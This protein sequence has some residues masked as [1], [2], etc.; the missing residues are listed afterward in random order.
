MKILKSWLAEFI[1]NPDINDL[2]RGGIEI[3]SESGDLV[4]LEI[5]ANRPDLLSHFGIARE[6]SV[7]SGR[8]LKHSAPV[9]IPSAP[10]PFPITVESEHCARYCGL[11]IRDVTIAPSPPALAGRLEALGLHPICNIVDATNYLLLEFGH[12]LHAFDLDRLRE[13]IVVRQAHDGESIALLDGSEK[14]LTREDLVIADADRAAALAGVMGGSGT[15]VGSETRDILLEAAWFN[16]SAVRRTA[17]RHRVATDSS[18]RFER[19]ADCEVLVEVLTRLA[20]LIIET[21]GGRIDGGIIDIRSKLPARQSIHFRHNSVKRVLG[22]DVPD[23]DKILTRLGAVVDGATISPPSW[24]VDLTR[25]IDLVE[26]VA[27]ISGYESIVSE[28]PAIPNPTDDFSTLAD[29]AREF[30]RMRDRVAELCEAAGL[31]RCVTFSFDAEGDVRLANPI[32]AEE[33]AM[34]RS[35]LPS[36]RRVA[37][38]RR[39]RAKAESI[40]LYEID[41]VFSER[42]RET[43]MLAALFSGIAEERRY[44]GRAADPVAIDHPIGLLRLLEKRLRVDIDAEIHEDGFEVNLVELF[45]K[46]PKDPPLYRPLPRFPSSERDI[47]FWID[48]D[49]P[50]GSCVKKIEMLHIPDLEQT[51]IFDIFQRKGESRKSIAIRLRFRAADRTLH[52]DEIAAGVGRAIDA[53]KLL[54]AEIRDHA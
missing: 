29:D 18:Y 4:E 43:L 10:G 25:E 15:G 46:I 13:R 45:T 1:D 22:H 51:E 14:K 33:S 41:K 20:H 39:D 34:R 54:G 27:R 3:A 5:Y 21:A 17:R 40:A 38:R 9:P 53:L 7:L 48:R 8:T 49:L 11:V 42:P 37:E 28:L 2:R 30:R 52:E 50:V 31:D 32:N 12:P 26:E 16:P 6:L 24:R 23:A 35:I 47:S 44:D 19:G 36:L